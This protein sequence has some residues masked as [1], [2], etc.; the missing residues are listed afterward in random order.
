MRSR[1]GI[2]VAAFA[3]VVLLGFSSGPSSLLVRT[4]PRY[5][6][7]VDHLPG[8]RLDPGDPI[9]VHSSSRRPARIDTGAIRRAGELVPNDAVYFVD[10]PSSGTASDDVA[11]AAQLFLLPAV[12][13]TSAGAAGWIL[14][15]RSRARHRPA[16]ATY[17]LSP[18]LR[19][20][21]VR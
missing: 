6:P 20:A 9:Y 12:R 19:L 17:V 16:A 18:D 1:I 4:F 13:S 3:G 11:L 15:Y 8:S 10:A 14:S 7:V 5:G 2:A 21:E